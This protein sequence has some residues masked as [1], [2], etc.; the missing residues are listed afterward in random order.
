MEKLLFVYFPFFIPTMN[1]KK[2][3]K[4]EHKKNKNY[5]WYDYANKKKKLNE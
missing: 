1:E 2:Y 5:V 4:N 3:N